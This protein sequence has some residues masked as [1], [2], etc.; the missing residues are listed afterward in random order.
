M[1]DCQTIRI[2]GFSECKERMSIHVKPKRRRNNFNYGS[3][4]AHTLHGGL[5]L[6]RSQLNG[7]LYNIGL[8][9]TQ[10]CLF[11]NR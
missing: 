8:S 10:G 1:T 9:N 6:D 3:T 4:Y 5:R 2:K 7:H 11:G